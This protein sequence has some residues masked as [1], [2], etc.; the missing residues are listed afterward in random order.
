M[1]EPV[2]WLQSGKIDLDYSTSVY[3]FAIAEGKQR[4]II[5][6][7]QRIGQYGAMVKEKK[8]VEHI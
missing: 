2:S 6:V 3:R 7:A 8:D 5:V 1:S 4:I